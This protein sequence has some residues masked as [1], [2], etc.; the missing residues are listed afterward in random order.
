MNRLSLRV[1][2]RCLI[3]WPIKRGGWVSKEESSKAIMCYVLL[4]CLEINT[5]RWLGKRLENGMQNALP[6][7]FQSF[8]T[9]N[10]VG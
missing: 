8:G 6:C 4:G 10:V 5:E 2:G 7:P 3:S 1:E 9:R